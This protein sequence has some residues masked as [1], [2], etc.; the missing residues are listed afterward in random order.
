MNKLPWQIEREI[1]VKKDISSDS[2]LGQDPNNR[3]IEELINFGVID[4]NKP[5]GP[6]SHLTAEYVKRI[7]NIKKAGHGGSLDPGVT[8]VLPIALGRATRIVDALLKAGKEY[9]GIMHLHKPVSESEIKNVVKEFTG[10]IVQVPPVKSAVV[11]KKRER[12]VYYFE[13]LEIEGKDVLFK[14][15]CQAGT[16]I[17][18]ICHD[19]G[20]RLKCGAHMSEL[21]R[22]KAG[23]FTEN[24]WVSLQDLEDAFAFWKEDNNDKFLRYCIKPIEFAVQHLPKVWVQDSAV[25]T[26]C[27]GADLKIP[28]ITRLQTKIN[29]DD[30]VAIMTGKDELVALGVAKMSSE[31]IKEKEKG[32]AVKTE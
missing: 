17:R 18:K 23:P 30:A 5:K 9:V 29:K 28:G 3:P 12:M 26:L 13:V 21:V 20:K 19:I 27:H 32:V 11:R 7:L 14:I 6:T 25:P 2:H 8:G 22:T 4:L 1:I 15:G 31:E 10:R 24:D 16:Y